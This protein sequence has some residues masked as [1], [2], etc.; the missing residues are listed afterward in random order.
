MALLST[1]YLTLMI[2][3]DLQCQLLGDINNDGLSDM[4]IGAHLANPGGKS[5][6]GQVYVLVW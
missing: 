2:A 3:Q 5:D 6:A 4:I 1:G